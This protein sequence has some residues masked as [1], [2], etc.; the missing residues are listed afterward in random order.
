V[1]V[2]EGRLKVYRED[3]QDSEPSEDPNVVPIDVPAET[4]CALD[5]AERGEHTLD[6]IGQIYGFTRENVRLME[7]K[8]LEI[9][10]KKLHDAGIV[11]SEIF[12]RQ[13]AVVPQDSED[14]VVGSEGLS[15]FVHDMKALPV[16]PVRN[17]GQSAD[18][19]RVGDLAPGK[20]KK[21]SDR[22]FTFYQLNRNR[23]RRAAEG[24]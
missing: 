4:S 8:G 16:Y 11:P 23:K 17:V 22:A 1:D 13:S 7:E 10:A 18:G 3:E 2:R 9:L 20:I 5:V 19:R 14:F 15:Q 21:R 24:K 6:E 12:G